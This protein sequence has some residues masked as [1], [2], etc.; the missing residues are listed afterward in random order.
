M[1]A[2][3]I[4]P[5]AIV[6][7]HARTRTEATRAR[8]SK[9]SGAMDTTAKVRLVCVHIARLR[10]IFCGAKHENNISK[11]WQCECVCYK[12]PTL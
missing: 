7:R 3:P 4:L 6:T 12:L 10:S 1:N 5:I 2:N 11:N 9:D 8:A